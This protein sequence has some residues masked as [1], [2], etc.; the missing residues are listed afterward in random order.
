M[1]TANRM[2]GA[3]YRMPPLEVLWDAA[4]PL[5]IAEVRGHAR[6]A[7]SDW[8]APPW[9]DS[10]IP[11]EPFHFSDHMRR[12]CGDIAARYEP[13][14]HIDVSRMIFAFAQSRNLR[15]HGLQARVTPLRFHNGDLTRVH[16]GV[17]F[18]VQRFIHDSRD[19]LY[20]MTFCLP[21]FLNRNFDDKFVTI[22][23]EMFHLSAA[24]DGD[25]RRHHGRYSVHTA[26]QKRYDEEMAAMAREYLQSGVDP[27]LHDFLRLNFAQLRQRHGSV[28]GYTT[29]RPKLIPLRSSLY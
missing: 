28:I 6:H 22:F 13:L 3:A 8:E 16:H 9:I 25:L 18:Q 23:H 10:G 20:V 14:Q 7:P 2:A 12:L 5:P 21:R 15:S 24:F 1:T 26:S 29:P 17:N 4:S 27:K 19:I 11:G